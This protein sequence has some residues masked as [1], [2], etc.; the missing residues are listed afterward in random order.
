M[1]ATH[2]NNKGILTI[3]CSIAT[4]NNNN[5]VARGNADEPTLCFECAAYAD[6]NNEKQGQLI[7][8]F[9]TRGSQIRPQK[10]YNN[11]P[12]PLFAKPLLR[13]LFYRQP[14][15]RIVIAIHI[16]KPRIIL[17]SMGIFIYLRHMN[18]YT[19]LNPITLRF[20]LCP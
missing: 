20:T 6:N 15:F 14:I 7:C 16:S 1:N 11:G 5:K 4:H 13:L 2:K 10:N 12:P 8:P 18:H 17:V 9:K 3:V 19:L